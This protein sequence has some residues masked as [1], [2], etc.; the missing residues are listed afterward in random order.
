MTDG[1]FRETK[2]YPGQDPW[3]VPF[4][5]SYLLVQSK[6]NNRKIVVRQF[7]NVWHME[8]YREMVVWS[9]PSRGSDHGA[10]IWAPELH[11]LNGRW[12]IYYAASDGR[13]RNHRMY[14]LEAKHPLGP[15][16]ELGKIFDPQHDVWSIDMTVLQH[17]GGLY[18]VWSSWEGPNTGSFQNLYIAPMS[19]PSTISGERRLISRPEHGWEMTV[20][21]VNEGPQV[22]RNPAGDAGRLFITYSADA[23]WSNAYKLGLL[24]LTGTDVLDPAAW[25][26]LHRPIFIGGGHACFLQHADQNVVFFHRKISPDPGWADREIRCEPFTWDHEGYPVI[27]PPDVERPS[28]HRPADRHPAAVGFPSAADTAT[29]APFQAHRAPSPSPTRSSRRRPPPAGG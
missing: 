5:N 13:I 29:S 15:Y 10:Q 14:V 24:E 8:H 9:P 7:A 11:A 21:A 18:A 17:D 28:T 27:G 23:S 2:P 22:L 1:I 26:K 6:A 25:T 19:D 12:Y 4:E 3:V 20:G 16:R